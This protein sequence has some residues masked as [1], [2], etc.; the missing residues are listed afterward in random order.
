MKR[1][2]SFIVVLSLAFLLCACADMGKTQEYRKFKNIYEDYCQGKQ[3]TKETLFEKAGQPNYPTL[4]FH[5]KATLEEKL[6]ETTKWQY[7]FY[8]LSDPANPYKLVIEFDDDGN[9]TEMSFEVILGG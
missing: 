3:Y 6:F 5:D 9:A 2:L 7:N 1:I 8:E 4:E